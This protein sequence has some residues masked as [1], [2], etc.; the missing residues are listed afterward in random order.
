MK[1]TKYTVL[2][3][4]ETARFSSIHHAYLF[5]IM[6][7]RLHP[8]HLIEVGTANRVL[9]GQYQGGKPTPEFEPHHTSFFGSQEVRT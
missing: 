1:R 6:W 8:L 9:V 7:S 2:A 5:A 3:G 4:D